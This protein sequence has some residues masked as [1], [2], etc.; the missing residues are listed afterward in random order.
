MFVI[1]NEWLIYAEMYKKDEFFSLLVFTKACKLLII[2]GQFHRG[3]V[4]MVEQRSPKP[5]VVSSSLTAPAISLKETNIITLCHKSHLINE[6]LFMYQFRY[7][8]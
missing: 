5:T 8:Y 6:L 3:I 2:L 1:C 4:L 7:F